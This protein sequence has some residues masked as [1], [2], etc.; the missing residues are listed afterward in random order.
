MEAQDQERPH[1]PPTHTVYILC[2]IINQSHAWSHRQLGLVHSLKYI[3]NA[4]IFVS[5]SLNAV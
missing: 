3:F 2:M 5:T 1:L 4:T